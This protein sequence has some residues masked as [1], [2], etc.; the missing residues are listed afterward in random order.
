MIQIKSK[1]KKIIDEINKEVELIKNKS[2]AKDLQSNIK[3]T[4]KN[5]IYDTEKRRKLLLRLPLFLIAMLKLGIHNNI[6][7]RNVAIAFKDAYKTPESFKGKINIIIK[8]F[9]DLNRNRTF[10]GKVSIAVELIRFFTFRFPKFFD[11]IDKLN[12]KEFK[13]H[14]ILSIL[15]ELLQEY[16][17]YRPKQQIAIIKSGLSPILLKPPPSSKKKINKN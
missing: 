5:T 17:F 8:T 4:I 12:K 14:N 1:Y 2:F 16:F 3:Y 11:D 13:R 10:M 9:A 7:F 15:F 6:V